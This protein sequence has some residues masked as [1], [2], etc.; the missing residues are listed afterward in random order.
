LGS[1]G[2]YF[3][4]RT[5]K[6][7]IQFPYASYSG[8]FCLG[9]IYSRIDAKDIDETEIV[10]VKELDGDTGQ[11]KQIGE[12]EVTTVDKLQSITSVIS[13]FEFFV[14]EK[15]QL[16]SD[17]QGSG[18]TANIGSITC[19]KDILNAKGVFSKLGEDVFDEY[20]INYGKLRN[21]AG[22]A[23]KRLADFLDFKKI[24]KSLIVPVTPKRR[25][26]NK[27]E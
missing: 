8:H 27:C 19:I 16:A 25:G 18:N 14:C 7:N 23:I 17:R 3:R 22:H 21:K 12:R 9:V 24:D 6:K 20:W 11:P 26:N 13:D 15:W 4:N 10:Q 1:H 2:A 5:E